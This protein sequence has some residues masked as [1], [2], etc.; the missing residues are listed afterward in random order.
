MA[1]RTYRPD[2]RNE[3]LKRGT[4]KPRPVE[5]FGGG[6]G[7]IFTGTSPGFGG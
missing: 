5:P 3:F 7:G 1:K 6:G 2:P 4:K